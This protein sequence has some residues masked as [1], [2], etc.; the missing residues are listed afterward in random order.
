MDN[1]LIGVSAGRRAKIYCLQGMT[2][3]GPRQG[4]S[5][6]IFY[7]SRLKIEAEIEKN[8]TSATDN[9]Q[10]ATSNCRKRQDPRGWFPF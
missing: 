6:F 10:L 8:Q 7:V 4:T 1:G 2:G 3:S 9:W 5:G